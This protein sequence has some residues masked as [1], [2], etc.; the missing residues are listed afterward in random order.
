M[1]KRKKRSVARGQADPLPVVQSRFWAPVLKACPSLESNLQDAL[2]NAKGLFPNAPSASSAYLE[3]FEAALSAFGRHK[4][5]PEVAAQV[6]ECF[7][8]CGWAKLESLLLWV[9]S[10]TQNDAEA[11]CDCVRLEPPKDVRIVR[12]LPI[13]G[14]QKIVFEASWG[15]HQR[16]VILKQLIVGDLQRE[17]ETHPLT[18]EHRNIVKTYTVS[19]DTEVFLV[20]EMLETLDDKWRSGGIEQTA[21]FLHDVGAALCFLK[22]CGLVHGDIKPDN[23]GIDREHRFILLD[24]GVCRRMDTVGT[25]KSATGS[26]RTRAPELLLETSPQTWRSDLWALGATTCSVAGGRFPLV[27]PEDE[28]PRISQ[29]EARN[30]FETELKRRVKSEY[31]DRVEHALSCLEDTRIRDIVQPLLSQAPDARGEPRDLVQKLRAELSY[32]VPD[33]DEPGGWVMTPEQEAGSILAM[34]PTP[35]ALAGVPQP[36]RDA[37]CKRMNDLADRFSGDKQHFGIRL[38]ALADTA[39]G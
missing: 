36:R 20:E 35:Q 4:W 2:T 23:V 7:F 8:S 11:V 26:L 15:L 24:F 33:S 28:V 32:A 38:K 5:T 19:N 31:S 25:G 6:L 1:T 30:A 29:P 18:N 16:T 37:L 14:S 17:L 22:D 27:D 34:W 21:L 9:R 10:H 39:S 13:R 3:A 12:R